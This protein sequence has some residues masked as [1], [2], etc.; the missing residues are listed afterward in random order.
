MWNE[1]CTESQTGGH[2]CTGASA[3]PTGC[4]P[5]GP[6]ATGL[7]SFLRFA[8]AVR[9]R[10]GTFVGCLA[11]VWGLG[12]L[13]YAL[14]PRVYE[15]T[16]EVMIVA[17]DRDD[18][19]LVSDVV[20]REAARKLAEDGFV[21]FDG[22]A[23]NDAAALVRS[24]LTVRKPGGRPNILSLSYRSPT[25]EESAAALDYTVTAF[26]D[27]VALQE[28]VRTIGHRDARNGVS[29]GKMLSVLLER[30]AGLERQM[31]RQQAD[32]FV[33]LR[34]LGR[35]DET[36]LDRLDGSADEPSG[37]RPA[38]AEVPSDE[39][40]GPRI[41]GMKF[42]LNDLQRLAEFS[43]I[44]DD[45]AD[46]VESDVDKSEKIEIIERPVVP[47]EPIS[48]R[49]LSH[50]MILTT[51]LGTGM[52]L[53][54]VFLVEAFDDRFRSGGEL[55]RTLGAP[56]LACIRGNATRPAR[57][58]QHAEIGPA[59]L[60]TGIEDL[61]IALDLSSDPVRRLVVSSVGRG[62]GTT[63]VAAGLAAAFA[64]SGRRTLL[65]DADL[66][67]HGLSARLGADHA[68]GLAS[69]LSGREPLAHAAPAA[70]VSLDSEGCDFLPCGPEAR[71][72]AAL[73][74]SDRF[75]ELL[76][77]IDGRYDWVVFDAPAAGEAA[78]AAI[79]GNQVDGVLLVV[80]PE[81]DRRPQATLAAEN[82][83]RFSCPLLGIV[84]HQLS[85]HS[86]WDLRGGFGS[87]RPPRQRPDLDTAAESAP[88]S[89][90]AR[91]K[92][93]V[94]GES[95]DDAADDSRGDTM[96]SAA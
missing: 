94:P 51:I 48:P 38:A 66:T 79:I 53:V 84:V 86:L 46:L 57:T 25:G 33:E 89:L 73:F 74:A 81:L 10:K 16:A 85:P 15:A 12:L 69:I 30:K 50:V 26:V 88:R 93:L 17:S 96:R 75:S 20:L 24:R 83:G 28:R 71:L 43:K 44:V 8:R 65:V 91:L 40:D 31:A 32:L 2:G 76:D 49:R 41:T 7:R 37:I 36:E 60:A 82:L 90:P 4:D 92:T 55:R 9:A 29:P 52:G 77:W 11:G 3:S 42:K 18:R 63:S 56:V 39:A 34:R 78:D 72:S 1:H 35:L 23:G 67:N 13:Y 45:L 21:Q 22:L 58:S 61:R 95:T 54:V 64:R 62:D 70:I 27:Y 14:A 19:L 87:A 80:R 6:E 5:P 47:A 59:D 68:R